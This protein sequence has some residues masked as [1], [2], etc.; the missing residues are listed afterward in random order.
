MT[1]SEPLAFHVMTKPSGAIC[2]LDC[3][4]CFYL[5]KEKLYPGTTDFFMKPDTQEAYIRQYIESQDVPEIHFAWQGGEPTLLGIP[6]FERTVELQKKYCPPGK[7]IFNAFQTNGTLVDDAWCEFFKKKDFLIGLSM[8]GPKA[9]HN[10]YRVTKGGGD[11]WDKVMNALSLLKKHAVEFN[12]LTVVNRELSKAP[13]EIYRFLKEHGSGYM[14]FIPLVERKGSE[15]GTLATPP[16]YNEKGELEE[17]S[18][19]TPWSVQPGDYGSFLTAIFDEWVRNDVGKVFVQLF[20]VQLGIWMGHPSSL[21]IFSETCGKALALEH[22]GDLYSCDHYV[23]PEHKLGNLFK[24]SLG[25][26]VRSEKQQKFGTDKKDTLPK[27]CRDCEVRFACNGECPKHRF[28]RTPDGE[29]GLNYLCAGYKRF[30]KHI[31]PYMKTM[32]GLLN[33]RRAPAEIMGMLSQQGKK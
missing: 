15:V 3:K 32:A 33:E 21:C 27:Y 30:F 10:R 28:F 1:S 24:E 13:L 11:T 20:D 18:S 2:N 4:Y 17:V 6:F 5:E 22:N 12:T 8:D 16:V 7:K 19:V 29:G 25:D 31:D 9:V 26:M 14:Q 23:Y